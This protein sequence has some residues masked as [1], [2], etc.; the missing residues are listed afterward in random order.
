LTPAF[1]TNREPTQKTSDG[2]QC[3]LP[4]LWETMS[5]IEATEAKQTSGSA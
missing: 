1:L 3:P 4:A 2:F 5:K